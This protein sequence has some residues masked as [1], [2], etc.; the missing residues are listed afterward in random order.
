MGR[1]QAREINIAASIIKTNFMMESVSLG[2]AYHNQK[3]D[4]WVI[5][6]IVNKHKTRSIL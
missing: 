4:E 5:C 3:A 6:L 2:A 1:S